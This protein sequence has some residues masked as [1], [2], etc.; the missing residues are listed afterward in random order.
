MCVQVYTLHILPGHAIGQ[1]LVVVRVTAII[2]VKTV[3]GYQEVTGVVSVTI[4][5]GSRTTA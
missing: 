5:S 1:S 4:K 2:K 3:L